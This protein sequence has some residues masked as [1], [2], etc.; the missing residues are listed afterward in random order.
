[1]LT[2]AEK[3]SIMLKA[4]EAANLSAAVYSHAYAV[5]REALTLNPAHYALDKYTPSLHEARHAAA[6][7][8]ACHAAEHALDDAHKLLAAKE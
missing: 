6:H 7:D 4:E 2:E 5:A 1:M 3:D 8:I